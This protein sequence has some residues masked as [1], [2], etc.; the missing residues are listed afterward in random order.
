VKITEKGIYLIRSSHSVIHYSVN[1]AASQYT[2]RIM[3]RCGEENGLLPVRMSDYAWAK[4]FP[5]LF[6]LSAEEVKP[7]LHIFRPHGYLYRRSDN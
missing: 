3:L 2:K 7:Y 6:T 1:K 4:E 5:Y